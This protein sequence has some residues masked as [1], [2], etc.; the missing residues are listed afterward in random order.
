MLTFRAHDI[1]KFGRVNG[2]LASNNFFWKLISC[3]EGEN[4]ERGRSK[5]TFAQDSRVLTTLPPCLP[6]FIF[7]HPLPPPTQ[8]M[9][10]LARIHPHPLNFYNCEI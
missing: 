5:S 10:V 7:E 2:K 1:M 9:F 4:D 8:G 3:A 6:L